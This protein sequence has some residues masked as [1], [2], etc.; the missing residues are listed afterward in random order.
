MR[1]F[2][3]SA[4]LRSCFLV[5]ITHLPFL[6]PPIPRPPSKYLFVS[7]SCF[8]PTF[9]SPILPDSPV[10]VCSI[11]GNSFWAWMRKITY[12]RFDRR[13][14]WVCNVCMYRNVINVFV[15]V[16]S[17]WHEY[18]WIMVSKA[19]LKRRGGKRFFNL[20]FFKYLLLYAHTYIC[21]Y[22]NTNSSPPQKQQ[23]THSNSLWLM[24]TYDVCF[25]LSRFVCVFS[26]VFPP[27]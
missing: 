6:Q 22:K 1:K 10:S 25:N 17:G 16:Y 14:V 20:L 7:K 27:S 12:V 23:V 15:F 24:P 19:I 4:P 5:T 8:P 21:T 26:P 18:G 13:V 2:S 3:F 9:T 11:R